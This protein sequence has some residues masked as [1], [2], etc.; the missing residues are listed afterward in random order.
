MVKTISTI[1][2]VILFGRGMP[3]GEQE[4][5][6]AQ[7]A[8]QLVAQGVAQRVESAFL[9]MTSPSLADRLEELANQG[10]KRV[11]IV[12][13]FAPYD[14][15]V[16]RWLPRYLAFWKAER[17]LSLEVVI[18]PEIE[19]TM[20]FARSVCESIATAEQGK[21]VEKINKPLRNRQ[22]FS[23]IPEHSYQVQ[24]CLGPRCTM[25][26]A[27]E[28][29]DEL[30]TSLQMHGLEKSGPRRVIPVR[31]ACLQPCNFAPVCSVQ[32][33]NVWYGEL[34]KDKV[35]LIVK[36]HFIEGKAVDGLAYRPGDRVRSAAHQA[37]MKDAYPVT[38]AMA[39]NIVVTDAFARPAM[40]LFDAGAV[41]MKIRNTGAMDDHLI[42]VE[43]PNSPKPRIHDATHSHRELM[44]MPFLTVTIPAG[45]SIELQPG[46][47]HMMLLQFR[48]ELVEGMEVPLTLNFQQ[49]G[50]ID[51]T[52]TLHPLV[53]NGGMVH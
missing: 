26:G 43:T 9:E 19:A 15:N 11:A 49:A 30:R 14:R 4:I 51:L 31:T 53:S 18:G 21:D 27:W 25:A 10:L 1:D 46:G 3:R 32:P 52:L 12:P 42:S 41:F 23:N 6:F 5:L 2:A 48:G 50:R 22:G 35:R 7:L 17:Q 28:I 34:T 47:L 16:K 38:Q 8:V 20:S 44:T 24:V 39:A 36:E 37:D 40:K 13:A 33:D 45:G 29:Y